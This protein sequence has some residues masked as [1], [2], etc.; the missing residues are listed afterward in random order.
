MSPLLP[1][2]L[3]VAPG[4]DL[5]LD[6]A[7][8]DA[9]GADFPLPSGAWDLLLRAPALAP[10]AFGAQGD[11]IVRPKPGF[12]NR[13]ELI[14]LAIPFAAAAPMGLRYVGQLRLTA[15]GAARAFAS[16]AIVR[17]DPSDALDIGPRTIRI[18]MQD[19]VVVATSMTAGL[20][21]VT[22]ELQALRDDALAARDEA[23]DSLAALP[24]AV[25]E[26][27]AQIDAAV[28]VRQA[29]A[30]TEIDAARVSA[31]D[32]VTVAGALAQ[33]ALEGVTALAEQVA[34]HALQTTDDRR[35]AGEDRIATGLDRSAVADLAGQATGTLSAGLESIATARD[36]ALA[37]VVATR[38]S[39]LEALAGSR[40]SALD[41][42]TQAGAAQIAALDPIAAAVDADASAA[43]QSAS[44]AS[45]DRVLTAQDRIATAADRVVTTADRVVTTADRARAEAAAATALDPHPLLVGNGPPAALLGFVGQAYLDTENGLFYP[46]RTSVGWGASRFVYLRRDD[47]VSHD[48]TTMAALPPEIGFARLSAGTTIAATGLEENLPANAPR[49]IHTPAGVRRGL[50]YEPSRSNLWTQSRN[51]ANSAWSTWGGSYATAASDTDVGPGG[52]LT[53]DRLTPVSTSRFYVFRP[54]ESGATDRI[55]ATFL[56]KANGPARYVSGGFS[57]G[58]GIQ[59]IFTVDLQAGAV[60]F[61]AA[62]IPPVDYGNGSW[63]CRWLFS[64]TAAPSFFILVA[65]S[66]TNAQVTN[67]DGSL[68]LI[69]GHAGVELVPGTS[70]PTSPIITTTAAVTRAADQLSLIVPPGKSRARVHWEGGEVVEHVLPAA[71]QSWTLPPREDVFVAQRLELW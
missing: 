11:F 7:F 65:R 35:Q 27:V 24:Q 23:R 70:R 59:E 66:A 71:G 63:L 33:G 21:L 18:V 2:A 42:V 31:L 41:A 68:S 20:G 55:F 15:G 51:M 50:L 13:L 14:A 58:A 45:A 26:S 46:P 52:A 69:V 43:A 19:E 29:L 17:D 36:G 64:A 57:G 37:D 3:R 67:T 4:E 12:A 30:L 54:P 49:F 62:S 32:D 53:A 61:G 1:T 9:A 38:T 60:P 16:V 39:S 6:F 48:F 28:D 47:V 10:I 56:L 5:R 34:G 40:T 25:S 22:P 8:F 44:D